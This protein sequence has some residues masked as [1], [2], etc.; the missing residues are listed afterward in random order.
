[1]EYIEI[2]IQ[3]ECLPQKCIK[4]LLPLIKNI[5]GSVVYNSEKLMNINV[6]P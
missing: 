4:C 1:M 5:Y 3:G 2:Y 6:H